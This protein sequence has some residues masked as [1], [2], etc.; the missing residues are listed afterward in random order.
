MDLTSK[1]AI[2]TGS[3]GPGCGRAIARRFAREGYATVVC[4]INEPG[5]RETVRLIEAER[6]R[7]AFFR[8][9]IAK[10]SDI[11]ALVAFTEKTFGGLDGLVNNASAP[12]HADAVP[13]HWL[14]AIQV[15]LHGA[16]YATLHAIPAM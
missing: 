6:G 16:I 11:E 2:G 8:A 13:K 5:G 7:A 3:G 12:Y 9:D 15:D 4:D 10:E 1:V 14:D